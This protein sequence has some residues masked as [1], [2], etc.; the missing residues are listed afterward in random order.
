MFFQL[1]PIGIGRLI[2]PVAQPW[3]PTSLTLGDFFCFFLET[4]LCI[5]TSLFLFLSVI[6][7]LL[8]PFSFLGFFLLS[9]SGA[10]LD[11]F[12]HIIHP[13]LKGRQTR[14]NP[15]LFTPLCCCCTHKQWNKKKYY[16]IKKN[17]QE[18]NPKSKSQWA[19][20]SAC[21][22]RELRQ[23]EAKK[24]KHNFSNKRKKCTKGREHAEVDVSKQCTNIYRPWLVH[25]SER[26]TNTS[27]T[28][29]PRELK[30][31][32]KRQLSSCVC[33]IK[34]SGRS[35]QTSGRK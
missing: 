3:W 13:F 23:E 16:I 18:S 4:R 15:P 26:K 12:N 30:E 25:L 2:P 6:F 19:L 29:T 35:R 32:C 5:Y 27:H 9:R 17:K 33:W 31:K 22:Q 20:Q 1:V 28:H 34:E 24:N 7:L 11:S 8:D 14:A 10:N 21:C